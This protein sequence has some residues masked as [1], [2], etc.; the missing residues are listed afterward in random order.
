[1][2]ISDEYKSFTNGTINENEEFNIIV[3]SLL[4]SIPSSILLL[5]RISLITWTVPKSLLT[6]KGQW[7]DFY[8][9]IILLGVS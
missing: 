3:E 5:C 9:Q 8:N 2:N 4:L 1:M 7:R 6:N